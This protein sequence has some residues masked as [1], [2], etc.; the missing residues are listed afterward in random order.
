M[1]DFTKIK[2]HLHSLEILLLQ[3]ETR[4]SKEK[5]DELLAVDFIEFGSSGRIFDKDAILSRLPKEKN[6]EFELMDFDARQLAPG[7]VLTTYRVLKRMDMKY[8]L[9]S[10]IWKL[11]EGKWQMT[12]HQGTNT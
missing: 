9:R 12:F 4:K 5:L 7:V 3:S 11:N 10:S 1:N 2:E 6:P 8:S